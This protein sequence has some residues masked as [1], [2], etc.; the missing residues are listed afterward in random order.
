VDPSDD[1][2]GADAKSSS[3]PLARAIAARDTRF[4]ANWVA[5]G[6]PVHAL[7]LH[8]VVLLAVANVGEPT[9]PPAQQ[10]ALVSIAKTLSNAKSAPSP[11]RALWSM[12]RY[13]RRF[14][15][16]DLIKRLLS[17]LRSHATPASID[18]APRKQ[19]PTTRS[20]ATD[21]VRSTK[22]EAYTLGQEI[23][24]AFGHMSRAEQE[25]HPRFKKDDD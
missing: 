11:N 23:L 6:H 18:W 10:N 14:D 21:A 2:G 3:D 1:D 20:M 25:R 13:Y 7:H 24:V 9:L 19:L 17:V 8:H 16:L 12:M 4:V 15:Q 22:N 5:A